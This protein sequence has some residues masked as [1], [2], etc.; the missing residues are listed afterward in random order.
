[1]NELKAIRLADDS[2]IFVEMDVVDN[3][4]TTTRS[5]HKGALPPGAEEVGAVDKALDTLNILKD[6][7]SSVFSTVQDTLKDNSP[8]EWGVELNIGFKGKVNPIPVIVGGE[9]NVA[10]KVHARWKKNQV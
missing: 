4:P 3:V 2:C 8:D 9:S 1:M 5:S 7:L 6:T 10:I